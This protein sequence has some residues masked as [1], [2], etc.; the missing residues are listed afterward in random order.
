V[1]AA[2]VDHEAENVREPAR[3]AGPAADEPNAPEKP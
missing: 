1:G 2:S 3:P